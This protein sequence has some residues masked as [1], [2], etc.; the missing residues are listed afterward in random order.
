MTKIVFQGVIYEDQLVSAAQ[1]KKDR[2]ISRKLYGADK[3]GLWTKL[4]VPNV[5][6][7]STQLP[8]CFRGLRVVPL[9]GIV[10]IER[11]THSCPGNQMKIVYSVHTTITLNRWKGIP[12]SIRLMAVELVCSHASV[13]HHNTFAIKATSAPHQQLVQCNR[14]CVIILV[15]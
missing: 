2:C 1:E 11:R 13:L 6:A 3:Y 5:K 8:L 15:I 9:L 4:R 14:I 7:C 10:D 12:V